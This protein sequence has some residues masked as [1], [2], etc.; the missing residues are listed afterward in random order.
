VNENFLYG[1]FPYA[2]LLVCGVGVSRLLQKRLREPKPAPREWDGATRALAMGAVVVA[3]N[4][5]LG[6]VMPGAMRAFNANPTRLF[7]FEAVS[8]VGALLLTWG[9][10]QRILQRLREG[11]GS[12]VVA[13]Y[14]GALLG[15]VLT[16]LHIAVAMRWGSAWGLHV[17]VPYLRSLLALQPDTALLAQAPMVLR[18]HALLGFL[19]LALAPFARMQPRPVAVRT[20][21]ASEAPVLASTRQ[22]TVP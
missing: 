17:V 11:L 7:L 1:Y 5:L 21:R 2:A 6:L 14:S 16:G 4:H 8:L 22:E 3:L 18:A 13:A 20:V 15:V 12:W 10:V 19:A 9:L